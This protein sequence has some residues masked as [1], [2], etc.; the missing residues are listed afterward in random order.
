MST[1]YHP[2]TDGQSEASNKCIELYMRCFILESPHEW[3]PM[4]PWVEFRYNTTFYSFAEVIPFQVLYRREPSTISRSVFGSA[5]ND[6]VEKYKLER[7][8]VLVLLQN[9]LFKA[10]TV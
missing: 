3:V 6:L 10:Q 7:D 5:A 2:Q 8:E 4:L 9:N 1:T